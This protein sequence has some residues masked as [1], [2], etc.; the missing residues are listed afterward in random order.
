MS[1]LPSIDGHQAIA[2]FEKFG[3]SVVRI[4]GS[5]HMMKKQGHRFILAVPVH[6]HKALK[7]GTLR[8]L[9]KAA[10]LTPEAMF[11]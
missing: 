2:E 7:P 1:K 5:H 11:D 4:T 6:G 10:G 3:F 8:G 9:I